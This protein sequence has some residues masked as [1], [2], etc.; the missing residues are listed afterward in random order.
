MVLDTERSYIDSLASA[1]FSV[2]L[3]MPFL[4]LLL[5][6]SWVKGQYILFI[7]IST[8]TIL[9]LS[10]ILHHLYIK[11]AANTKQKNLPY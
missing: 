5:P 1:T 3:L 2:S 7:C 10:L 4:L 9:C 6:T 8:A 11:A